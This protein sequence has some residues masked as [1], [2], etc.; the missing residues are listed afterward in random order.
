[1]AAVNLLA[2]GVEGGVK[3]SWPLANGALAASPAWETW[4]LGR[5]DSPPPA[6]LKAPWAMDA[7]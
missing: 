1:M 7:S 6:D 2:S 3:L 4:A 5:A